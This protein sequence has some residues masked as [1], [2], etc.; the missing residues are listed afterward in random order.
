MATKEERISEESVWYCSFCKTANNAEKTVCGN[1][2]ESRDNSEMNYFETM[3]RQRLM[4]EKDCFIRQR[5]GKGAGQ[6]H[7]S[8]KPLQEKPRRNAI[9][10]ALQHLLKKG[11]GS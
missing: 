7:S 9:R 5:A 1:C 4:A 3:R 2:G 11:N 8:A 6:I 10:T